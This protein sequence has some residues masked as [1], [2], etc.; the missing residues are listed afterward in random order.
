MEGMNMDVFKNHLVQALGDE[1]VKSEI[2]ELLKRGGVMPVA[3]PAESPSPEAES[4]SQA[5][6]CVQLL[7]KIEKLAEENAELKAAN[8]KLTEEKAAL[9]KTNSELVKEKDFL[10]DEKEKFRG[11]VVGLSFNLGLSQDT[12]SSLVQ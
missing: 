8:T 9:E 10:L 12:I 4:E 1:N 3:G 11:M 7:A 2:V 6:V 5:D